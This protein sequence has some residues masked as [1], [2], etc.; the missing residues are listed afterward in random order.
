M[1]KTRNNYLDYILQDVLGHIEGLHHRAMFG[2]VGIYKDG[3]IFGLIYD[4]QLYFKVNNAN[5]SRYESADSHPFTYDSNGKQVQ[6]S[7]WAVPESVM[8][9]S[10][11]VSDWMIQC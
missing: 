11:A 8:E 4:N 6:L 2:G 9:D 10:D 1:G 3:V 7:Y 5:R